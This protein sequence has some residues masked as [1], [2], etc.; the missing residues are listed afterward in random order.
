M[1]FK[2]VLQII[3]IY[4]VVK[5]NYVKYKSFSLSYIIST[6]CNKSLISYSNLD[7][8]HLF[9]KQIRELNLNLKHTAYF[10]V[11]ILKQSCQ[12]IRE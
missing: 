4:K 10:L 2:N 5:I 1:N 6:A 3:S 12:H 7:F 9:T 11:P 8:S